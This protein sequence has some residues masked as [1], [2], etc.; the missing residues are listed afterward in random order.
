MTRIL[1]AVTAREGGAALEKTLTPLLSRELD[2][3]QIVVANL[4]A[5]DPCRQ[6]FNDPRL[7]LLTSE[8][9]N[10][11]Q[12]YQDMLLSFATDL[13]ILLPEGALLLPRSAEILATEFER[14]PRAVALYTD[15]QLQQQGKT[16]TVTPFLYPRDITERYDIGPLLAL[17]TAAL[18]EVGGFEE[19]LNSAHLYDLR[20]KL[21]DAGSWE[22]IEQP[23]YSVEAATDGESTSMGASRVFSPGVGAQ[24]G[25]SYLYYSEAEQ[26][27]FELVFKNFLSRQGALIHV[28]PQRV[29]PI[30]ASSCMVSV[31]IPVHNRAGFIERAVNSVLQGSYT[32][33]E[34]I[35]VDNGSDDGTPEL[36]A[37]LAARDKRIRL[38]RNDRNIIALSLNLG[39]KAAGGRY[40]SQLDSDDEYAPLA[41]ETAVKWMEQHPSWGLGIS[42]YDL[43]DVEG[44]RLEEFGIVRHLEYDPNNH[45][46][47]D[48]AGAL[49][50][51]HRSVL[52]EMGLFDE[53]KYGDFGEDYE[54]VAKVGEKYR[55]GRIPAVLYHYRRHPD[56]TD[57]RRSELMKIS[58][59]TR[60]RWEAIARRQR[61][62]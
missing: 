12:F 28:R 2:N 11:A 35:V 36:V 1:F 61:Q 55:V 44:N 38:L 40:I 26:T 7:L 5:D 21:L 50:C 27:E 53:E 19:S 23:L 32:D 13:I 37:Q 39:I 43:M 30:A 18:H 14:R 60:A 25:F 20:L 24:G 31:V 46:R 48:G 34:I 16:T 47:V 58:N 52:L 8:Y 10:Q 41:L 56:N 42:Y 17:R 33:F 9:R 49:R 45:L 62:P 29:V 57:V 4:A 6:L 22:R 54:M 51:W 59:K 3:I 15:Y